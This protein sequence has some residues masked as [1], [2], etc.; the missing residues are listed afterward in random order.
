[1]REVKVR[2]QLVRDSLM[3]RELTPVIRGD[4]M[5]GERLQ[6]LPDGLPD[7]L[8]CVAGDFAEAALILICAPS[9]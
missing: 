3:L 8:R 7:Q 1:M 6:L 5:D 9:G 2:L 4:R